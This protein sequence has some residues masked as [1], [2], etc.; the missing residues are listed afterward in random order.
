MTTMTFDIAVIGGGMA[1]ASV[2]AELA[3]RRS[4]VLL[5]AEPMAG[6]RSTGRSAA[7]YLPSYGSP[8][9]RRLTVASRPLFDAWSSALN[10]ELLRPRP[11]I[12]L[13]TDAVSEA[14][15][16]RMLQENASL[17]ALTPAEA[18]A[19]CP[20]LRPE[21]IL[22]ALLDSFAMDIDVSGLHQGSLSELKRRKGL[23]FYRAPVMHLRRST[24][25]SLVMAGEHT[26]SCGAVVNGAGA[27]ADDVAER[28][29]VPPVGL[30]PKLRSAFISKPQPH[31]ALTGPALVADACERWYF[32]PEVGSVL[33]SPADQTA[34]PPC[35]ARPDE[36]A[37]T[38][39]ID[40][41]NE[42]TTLGLRSVV[43]AWAGLRTFAPDGHQSSGLARTMTG[44][45]SSPA[46][47]ATAF[48]WPQPLPSWLQTS[49]T[50]EHSP[51]SCADM[52]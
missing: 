33:A 42:V 16:A 30:Q 35:D 45:A 34:S 24:G 21:R 29:G 3:Q 9:V 20:A 2:A 50:T 15:A 23:V 1:G 52:E 14:A 4:V 26:I 5:E 22:M 8:A 27:W 39:A 51:T 37:I 13:S 43:L 18:S 46:K 11:L 44:S 17:R 47:V 49:S 31:S 12:W 25:A 10:V 48:R 7:S 6:V 32:K 19:L 38:Q 36:L 41:I 28:A 40:A